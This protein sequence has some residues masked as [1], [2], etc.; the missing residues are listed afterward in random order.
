MSKQLNLGQVYWNVSATHAAIQ[1]AMCAWVC[2][3]AGCHQQTALVV[4]N[5]KLAVQL[6]V[7]GRAYSK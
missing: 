4:R 1:N 3:T 6:D 2:V 7:V 5:S